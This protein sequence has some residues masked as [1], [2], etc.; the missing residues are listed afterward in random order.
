MQYA[1]QIPTI[2]PRVPIIDWDEGFAKHWNDNS[3]ASTHIF[4]SFSFLFPQGEAF[5][6]D[7]VKIVYSQL[8]TKS[9]LKL[10]IAVKFFITQETMHTK[11]HDLYNAILEKQGYKNVAYNWIEFIIKQSNKYLSPKGR[12]AIVCAFE[13]YT[14]ILGNYVLTNLQVLEFADKKMQLIWGWHAAEEIEHK[15]VCYDLYQ[16]AGGGWWLRVFA[17]FAVSLEFFGLFLSLY[18]N[19]LWRDG[20]LR[21]K[22]ILKTIWQSAKLFWGKSGIAWH[23]LWYGAKYLKPNFHP[24]GQKNK[25]ELDM[26]LAANKSNL[27]EV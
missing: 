6:I 4:N 16:V 27:K 19:L 2:I 9:D 13:H 7:T 25:N 24:W 18:L 20:C 3:P 5:F 21:P 10:G 1:R 12:L 8:K 11:Y 26:W 23:V 15:A 17:F 14:A 22:V